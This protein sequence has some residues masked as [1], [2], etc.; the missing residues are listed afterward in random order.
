M[1]I[2]RAGCDCGRPLADFPRHFAREGL[3]WLAHECPGCGGRR[4]TQVCSHPQ[5][6][7]L[8]GES[9]TRGVVIDIH[10]TAALL[11][12]DNGEALV[13]LQPGSAGLGEWIDVVSTAADEPPYYLHRVQ[14]LAVFA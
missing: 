11:L 5:F 8:L 10:D 12:M 13:H 9:R 2:S 7:V 3:P 14:P 4:E 6:P 1:A